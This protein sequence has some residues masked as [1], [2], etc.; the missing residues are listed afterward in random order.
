MCVHS[1]Q[2]FIVKKKKYSTTYMSFC[3]E[4]FFFFFFWGGGGGGMKIFLFGQFFVWTEDILQKK[5]DYL[6]IIFQTEKWPS[7]T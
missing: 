3:R 2:K 1:R 5:N 4:V 7:A 6:K